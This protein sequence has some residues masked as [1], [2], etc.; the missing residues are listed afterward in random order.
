MMRSSLEPDNSL[1]SASSWVFSSISLVTVA[2]NSEILVLSSTACSS[3]DE[4]K[5]FSCSSNSFFSLSIFWICV[6]SSDIFVS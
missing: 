6:S 3:L 2:S 5:F 4:D 1:I